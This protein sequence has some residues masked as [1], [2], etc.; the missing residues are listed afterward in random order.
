[1]Q[2]QTLRTALRYADQLRHVVGGLGHPLAFP[3]AAHVE[4]VVFRTRVEREIAALKKQEPEIVTT[5]VM[6]ERMRPRDTYVHLGGDFLRK[7]AHVGPGAPEPRPPLPR[8][9]ADGPPPNR[10]D[11][12]RWLVDPHNP[13]TPRVTVNRLWQRYFGIGLVETENDFGTQGT[14]PS[15]PAL[16]DWLAREFVE[17]GWGMKAVHRLIVTSATYRQASTFRPEARAKAPR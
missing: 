10:L 6:Q 15:H 4:A 5:L 1:Q 17:H 9:R 2:K 7:A 11:L 12:A 14:P 13:L 3:A 8:G 16:L